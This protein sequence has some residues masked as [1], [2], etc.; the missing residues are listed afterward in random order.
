MSKGLQSSYKHISEPYVLQFT[1]TELAFEEVALSKFHKR[2]NKM[3][4]LT[5]HD[6]SFQIKH[7]RQLTKDVQKK[8]GQCRRTNLDCARTCH[9]S[10]PV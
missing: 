8:Q 4:C 10:L 2:I 3:Y 1:K 7:Q 9:L 6:R 5:A